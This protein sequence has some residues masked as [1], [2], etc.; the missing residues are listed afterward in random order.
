MLALAT[1][2]RQGEIIGLTWKDVDLET[3]RLT[4]HETKNG[5][6]RSVT[7][8]GEALNVLRDHSKVRRIDSDLVFPGN[9]GKPAYLRNAWLQALGDAEIKD[10]RWH[11]IRHTSASY[12]A[13]SGATLAEIAE[14]LGH[15]TLQMV[16]RYA[17]LTEDHKAEVLE[18]M[19]S[20]MVKGAGRG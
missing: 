5:E 15:K 2:A 8:T 7:V 6:R 3:G 20:K 9:T 11:D 1:G 12:L 10:F 19:T 16:K 18:R 17:H 13:M 14:I 4:F